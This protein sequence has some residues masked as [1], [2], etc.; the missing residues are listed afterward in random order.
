MASASG[1]ERNVSGLNRL[2]E[3]LGDDASLLQ[4]VCKTIPKEVLHLPGPDFNDRVVS[5]TDRPTRVLTSLQAVYNTGRLGGHGIR[6]DP[7]R[8]SGYR[9]FRRRVVRAQP[10]LLRSREHREAG[11][12]G[13][14]QR[15]CVDA[16]GARIDRA[17]VRAPDSVPREAQSQRVSFLSELVRPDPLCERQ[18]GVRHG[19]HGRRRDHLFRVGG[20]E[21]AAPGSRRD[22]PARARAGHVHRA[23][24]LPSQPCVQ[25]EGC[26]L[27]PVRRSHRARRTTSA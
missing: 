18:A 15:R 17:Q 16:G 24:D 5:A 25:D 21:A 27:P 13:R 3:I 2:E 12:G 1:I 4:H 14:L 11:A 10:G 19:R 23:L 6:L 7:A 9:A 20:V 8:G 22:V 26:R